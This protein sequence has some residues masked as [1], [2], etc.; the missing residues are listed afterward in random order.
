MRRTL[1]IFAAAMLPLTTLAAPNVQVL[2]LHQQVAALQLDH[3]LN[4][5]QQQA[6]ALLPLLQNAKAKLQAQRSATEPALVTALAQAVSD[7]KA[8][9]TVSDATAQAYDAAR[10]PPGAL[11]QDMRSL[12]QQA[13]QILTPDQL[14]AL[15]TAQL[16]IPRSGSPSGRRHGFARRFRLMHTA[17]SDPFIAAVQA[18][19]A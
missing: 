19:A 1:W 7:L 12:W 10:V 3:A 11:R 4:L 17:L 6:Q 8:T 14:Q 9:G 18:R 16:G 15:K 13:R 5:T 2:A